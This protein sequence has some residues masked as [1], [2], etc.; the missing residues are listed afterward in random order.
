MSQSNSFAANFGYKDL[1]HQY[2]SVLH[3]GVWVII[4][5][6]A[7]DLT[8][9]LLFAYPKDPKTQPSSF[10]AYF[11]YG[12]STEGQLRR[13]TRPGRDQTAPITLA[14][15][16]NPLQVKEFI[17][18]KPQSSIVTIYGASHSV[19]LATALG[20]V[21]DRFTPRSV[22]G[23]GATSNWEYG[24]YLRDRG[25]G[26]SHAVVL[27]FQSSTLAMITT[28]SPMTWNSDAPKPYTADRFLLDGNQLQVIQPPYTSFEGYVATLDDPQ[29]WSIAR[30]FFAEYDPLYNSW[31]FRE[32]IL[33]HSSLF[34]L[35]RRAYGQHVIRNIKH[36]V[37][38]QSGFQ[39]D[40][41]PIRI[42]RAIIHEF[43]IRA[44]RDGSIPVIFLVNDLGYSNYLFQALSPIL[45]ADNIPYLSSDAIVSPNDPRGYLPDSHFTNENDDKLARALDRILEKGDNAQTLSGK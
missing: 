33:D 4:S 9:N 30:D 8:I 43:A 6:V 32:N 37:L 12:R 34:R 41:E 21:S 23:P 7:I 44:R 31:I 11:D 22:G 42:A 1:R 40:S 29:K 18:K 25:G 26:K 14:G 2:G 17:P 39:P 13:M 24:A 15:W 19:N 36:A 45:H 20:R 5:L 10:Q 3:V 28:L 27:S 35:V 38:D 16:Y